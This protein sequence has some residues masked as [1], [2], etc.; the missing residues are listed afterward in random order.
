MLDGNLLT[1]KY[2]EKAWQQLYENAESCIEQVLEATPPPPSSW[3]TATYHPSGKLYKLD[4]SDMR[5]TVGEVRTKSEAI[6]SCG[7]L[8]MDEQRQDDQL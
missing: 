8:H 1:E 4:E 5:D 6:Y 3:C 7:S 2:R